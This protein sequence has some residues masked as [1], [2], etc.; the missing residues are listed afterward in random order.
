MLKTIWLNAKSK[1]IFIVL[2]NFLFLT[3][4]NAQGS[5]NYYVANNGDD[6]NPGTLSQPF[7]TIDAAIQMIKQA[8]FSE[9]T[10]YLRKGA[11]T[12]NKGIVIP[13]NS[14]NKPKS[15]IISN[16]QNEEV[17]ISGGKELDNTKFQKVKDISVL[18]R[19]PRIARNE[20]Y[21]TDLAQ[22]GVFDLGTM[23][24]NGVKF[25]QLP[26]ALE[27]FYNGSPLQLAR[28]PNDSILQIGNVVQRKSAND[29]PGFAFDT[30][31]P[32]NWASS[33]DKWI[34]G[35]FAVGYAYDNLQ[36]DSIDNQSRTLY[37]KQN[38]SYGIYNSKDVSN[39]S[40]SSARIIRGFFF[41]NI[42][43]ELDRPGEWYLDNAQRK[44]YVWPTAPIRYA[45]IQ[46]SLL[47]QP[48][49]NL[50]GCENV[51]IRNIDFSCTRGIAIQ[52]EK[53]NNILIEKCSFLNTG[54][55]AIKAN[56]C[57]KVNILNCTFGH[58][59]SGAVVLSGGDR[60]TL[61]ASESH[62]QNCEFYDYSR[63][64]KTYTPAVYI[65]GVGNS[66]LNC[67]I[68]DAADQAITFDGNNHVI[69]YNHIKHVCFGFS[70]MGSVYTGRDPSSTGTIITNNF[71]D[72]IQ[73]NMGR[74]AA[75]YVDDGSGGMTVN[76]NIFYHSGSGGFGAVHVNGGSDNKFENNVFI[77]CLKAFSNQPWN[78]EQW[79][80]LYLRNPIYVKRLT[81]TVDIRSDIYLKQ[82][83]FLKGFF[84]TTAM[85]PRI[86][87]I[88]N[89]ICYRVQT[90]FTGAS[91][92]L[93]NTLN[94][95]VNPGFA[96]MSK[97]NFTLLSIPDSVKQWQNWKA[98]EFNKI[99]R[100]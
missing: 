30:D 79:K 33:T 60:K 77:E 65:G 46:V 11:Y 92:I 19:L 42:L 29:L 56:T 4:S 41:Y 23:K 72:N 10:V 44:L 49:L 70:D 69:S 76:Q 93:T 73:N 7:H 82:Y 57:Y 64:Y 40:I 37:V 96:D 28:W 67:F 16:Y 88:N 5:A 50:N 13:P 24:Q 98:I 31:R 59:G 83:P 53:S 39:G 6:A 85:R 55:Q 32:L 1:M 86:N 99:G 14:K 17:N 21:V 43:E 66:V 84:D 58:C 87:F 9:F 74:I 25:P 12:L 61:T 52:I 75:V 68:H 62:V 38:P 27:L 100:N 90:I 78:D 48:M 34:G 18:N 36:V 54:L 95:D 35:L 97:E 71:F 3:Q 2:S 80:N 94:T 63:L 47:E 15:I 89:T 45:N 51:I 26:A 81:V 20:V 91:Y 8:P 22:Q